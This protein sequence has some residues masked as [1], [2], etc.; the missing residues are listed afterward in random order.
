MK[1]IKET[2]T[3]YSSSLIEKI[4]I[5]KMYVLSKAIYRFSTIPSNIL[6]ALIVFFTEIE[7]N[8]S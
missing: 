8:N 4:E 1:E 7:K 3:D 2:Q 5:I 6:L